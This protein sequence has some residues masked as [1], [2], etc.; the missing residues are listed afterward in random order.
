MWRKGSPGRHLG[1]HIMI[2]LIPPKP[3]ASKP[4]DLQS[5]CLPKPHRFYCLKMPGG[6]AQAPPAPGDLCKERDYGGEAALSETMEE[7]LLFH[8]PVT[9]SEQAS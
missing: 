8:A 6:S 5:R 2:F 3:A 1:H 9:F 7:K 4:R